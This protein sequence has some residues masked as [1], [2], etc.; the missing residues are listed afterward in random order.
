MPG[1]HSAT[2]VDQKVLDA[3]PVLSYSTKIIEGELFRVDQSEC[4]VCLGELEEGDMVRLLPN[5]GH[6]FHVPC[7]DEWF[8]A[9]S[10]CPICRAPIVAPTSP[11]NPLSIEIERVQVVQS[12]P[13]L[14]GQGA[15][16]GAVDVSASG[17][18]GA[19]SGGWLRH[20]VSLV[21][22]REGN[23]RR[24]S[25]GLKRSFSMGHVAHIDHNIQKEREEAFSASSSSSSLSSLSIKD[26]PMHN[27]LYRARSVGQLDRKSMLMRSFFQLR[28]GRDS[29]RADGIL[30][31]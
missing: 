14:H 30:P 10:N 21:L 20:C 25:T 15:D 22:P 5:C 18:S 8:L 28:L 3:I 6:A 26:V 12:S 17:L 13:R 27:K 23:P 7:I 29:S 1:G 9:H 11:E 31:Y 2:G 19:R 16:H 4:V 24:V